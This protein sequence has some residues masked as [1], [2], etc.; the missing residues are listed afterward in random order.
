[1]VSGVVSTP[2]TCANGWLAAGTGLMMGGGRGGG[3][4]ERR[5]GS[6]PAALASLMQG[7]SHAPSSAHIHSSAH[8]Y[9]SFQ[10]RRAARSAS[11][12]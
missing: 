3:P 5:T 1:M 10:D 2:P 7:A 6:A 8:T 12:F 4:M 9:L 11:G